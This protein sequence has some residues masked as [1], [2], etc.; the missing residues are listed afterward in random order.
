MFKKWI[1][2]CFGIDTNE[3]NS[4]TICFNKIRKL[5]IVETEAK[6]PDINDKWNVIYFIDKAN[7]TCETILGG[8]I[9]FILQNPNEIFDNNKKSIKYKVNMY[10]KKTK[11]ILNRLTFHFKYDNVEMGT[12]LFIK[13]IINEI[14]SSNHWCF[15][16][17]LFYNMGYQIR[18]KY[19]KN[20]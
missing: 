14:I 4:E 17:S 19:Y 6:L 9:E 20:N 15:I 1:S 13:P 16:E 12:I 10:N 5:I 2:K 3:K 11:L 7:N 8:T 18:K